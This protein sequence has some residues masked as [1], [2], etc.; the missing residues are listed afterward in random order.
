[1]E[2]GYDRIAERYLDDA[3]EARGP[4]SQYRTFVR[5]VSSM[6][7]AGGRVVDLGCGAGEP[8]AG[9]LAA[10]ATVVGVD[11]SIRQ[12][13]LAEDRA[14]GTRLIRAD[15]AEVHFRDGVL[16]GV[17]AF[18]SII[19]VPREAHAELY[20]RIARWLRPGGV[21]AGVL[22]AGDNPRE[23]ASDFFGAPMF[24]SHFDAA[25]NLTML[26]AAGLEVIEA[27]EVEEVGERPLWVIARRPVGRPEPPSGLTTRR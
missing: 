8:V 4:G 23:L 16:H 18:F 10:R 6:I 12:L 11:L 25:T 19:H 7:P 26:R 1:M 2:E 15:M 14:P 20:R 27:E 9:E 24:W 22:G 17:V 13:R 3:R 5:R 21:F